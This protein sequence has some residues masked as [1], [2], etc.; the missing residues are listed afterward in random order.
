MSDIKQCRFCEYG[1]PERKKDDLIRCVRYSCFVPPAAKCEE[2][3]DPFKNELKRIW[4]K[5]DGAG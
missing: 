3:A 2:Y 1:K 4:E 5:V